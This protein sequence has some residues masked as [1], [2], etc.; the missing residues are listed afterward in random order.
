MS[1]LM[2]VPYKTFDFKNST[3][4]ASLLGEA[5]ISW[6]NCKCQQANDLVLRAEEGGLLAVICCVNESFKKN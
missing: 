4:E 6:K 3:A 2:D 5:T 1:V